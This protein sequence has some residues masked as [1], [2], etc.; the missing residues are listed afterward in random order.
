MKTFSS[1]NNDF[2]STIKPITAI[3]L[4]MLNMVLVTRS[5]KMNGVTHG[6]LHLA[7]T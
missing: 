5:Y 4:A 7:W 1:I 3:N 6:N 2:K